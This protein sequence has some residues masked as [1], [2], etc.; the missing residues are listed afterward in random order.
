MITKEVLQAQLELY[1]KGKQQALDAFEKVKADVNSFNGAIEAVETLMR[2][3][4]SLT[5]EESKEEEAT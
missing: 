3:E 1:K 2:L 4:E 5:S